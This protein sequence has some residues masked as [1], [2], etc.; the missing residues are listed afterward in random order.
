MKIVYLFFLLCLLSLTGHTQNVYFRAMADE[1]KRNKETLSIPGL[2][3][4]FFIAYTIV[5]SKEFRID[6]QDGA[7]FTAQATPV[8]YPVVR[9]VVGDT[10]FT[11]EYGGQYMNGAQRLLPVEHDYD[12]IR[13]ILWLSTDVAYR[14]STQ[15]Y[16]AKKN[17]VRQMHLDSE[18]LSVPD[19]FWLPRVVETISET[20]SAERLQDWEEYIRTLMQELDTYQELES[21][22]LQLSGV[23]GK[24]YYLTSENSCLEYPTAV[25]TLQIFLNTISSK[26]EQ[27]Q[28]VLELYGNSLRDFPDAP[29]LKKR[30]ATFCNNCIAAGKAPRIDENYFG[31]VLLEGKAVADFFNAYL[32]PA[33]IARK[34]DFGQRNVRLP[35]DK[36]GKRITVPNLNVQSL[37]SLKQFGPAKLWGGFDFDGDGLQP[38]DSLTLLSAGILKNLLNGN[39][40]TAKIKTPNG[41]NRRMP[42]NGMAPV[43]APGVLK[44]WGDD[45]V[46]AAGMKQRLIEAAKKEGIE[47]AYRIESLRNRNGT[48]QTPQIFKVYTD[49]RE[50]RVQSG[51]LHFTFSSLRRISAVSGELQGH[52]SYFSGVPVSYISPASLLIEELEMEPYEG[53]KEIQHIVPAPRKRKTP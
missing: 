2:P 52:N 8:V 13:R 37:P 26:G 42:G 12:E 3:A 46:D 38:Q 10:L 43:T 9:V 49:G 6:A 41:Y 7:V 1:M 19:M 30:L 29:T 45:S 14:N 50:Q 24:V 21:Y 18:Q 36:S 35:E 25:F 4:P 51:T 40:P 16:M 33:F 27:M 53:E 48:W 23:S 11:N 34:G 15:A 44:I 17:L 32:T 5:D 31:P 20:T 28:D 39:V 22:T 47:Y